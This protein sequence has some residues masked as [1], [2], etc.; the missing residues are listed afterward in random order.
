[1]P[2]KKLSTATIA[3]ALALAL[4]WACRCVYDGC[5]QIFNRLHYSLPKMC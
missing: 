3:F 2:L 1:M 4:S 5:P